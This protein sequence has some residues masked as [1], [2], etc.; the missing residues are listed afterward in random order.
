MDLAASVGLH[1][2]PW[3]CWVLDHALSERADGKW[4]ATSCGLNV[5]RQNGKGSIL[6]ALEVA[7]LFLF[8][9]RLILHTAHQVSTALV[10]FARVRE[11]IYNSDDLSSKV[12]TVYI[13]NGKESIILKSGQ[14]LR[15]IAR[16]KAGGRGFTGD[17]LVFDEGYDLT[18]AQL[19]AT[20]PTLA[21]RSLD[22]ADNPQIWFTS[23]APRPDSDVFHN[24]RRRGMSGDPDMR[25]FYAE[26]SA[27]ETAMPG[28]IDSWYQ[29]NPSLGLRISEEFIGDTELPIMS[30]DEFRRE[31]Q[32]IPLADDGGSLVL[33]SIMWAACADKESSRVGKVSLALDVGP[34]HAWASLAVCGKRADGL[35]H[36]EVIARQEG[37]GWL[38]DAA[39]KATSSLGV[40]IHV[41]EKSPAAGVVQALRSAGVPIV[42]VKD[43]DYVRACASL[44]DGVINGRLRHIDQNQLNAAVAG[45]DIRPVGDAWA[46]SRK[47]S[48]VDITPLVAVTLAFGVQTPS[49]LVF[50]Y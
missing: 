2:Y 24:I 44:Q 50:A 34:V 9:E 31:R 19:G 22:P 35:A 13:A 20:V 45:A 12:R 25:M 14:E 40:P 36:V 29:A 3:Q 8:G 27:D 7:G 49:S 11:L 46:W 33:P 10:H 47:A 38:I 16:S 28:D 6:E 1:L 39:L 42:E 5:P 17:R 21:A 23:S 18:E 37:S 32:G 15:F 30:T 26:W 48:T 4:C 43:A 41:L